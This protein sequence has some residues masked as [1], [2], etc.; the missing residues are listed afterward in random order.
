MMVLFDSLGIDTEPSDVSFS[1]SSD[2]GQ[3][4]EWGTKNGLRSVFAQKRNL[5]KSDFWNMLREIKK[6]REDVIM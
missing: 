2:S 1:V 4:F 5:L 6:F 3:G